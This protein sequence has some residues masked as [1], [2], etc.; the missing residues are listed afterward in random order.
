MQ[1]KSYFEGQI[2][3]LEQN[4]DAVMAQ[5]REEHIR[6]GGVTPCTEV[7]TLTEP[8]RP[9]EGRLGDISPSPQGGPR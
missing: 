2:R 4:M 3:T 9:H 5:L 1:V 7:V 6:P 8:N